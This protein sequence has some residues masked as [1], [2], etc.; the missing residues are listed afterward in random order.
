MNAV[1]VRSAHSQQ[2]FVQEVGAGRVLFWRRS[3]ACQAWNPKVTLSIVH[4]IAMLLEEDAKFR[5]M[6]GEHGVGAGQRRHITVFH[7]Q[8]RRAQI[9]PFA[10]VDVMNWAELAKHGHVLLIVVHHGL[11]VGLADGVEDHRMRHELILARRDRL[12]RDWL[13]PV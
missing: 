8:W 11:I 4:P 6:D 5:M 12:S 7:P 2:F 3:I 13:D 9:S 10:T 1:G